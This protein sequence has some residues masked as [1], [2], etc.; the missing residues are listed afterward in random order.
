MYYQ[1][2][3]AIASFISV[4]LVLAAYCMYGFAK[5]QEA[6]AALLNDLNFWSTS[7]LVFIGVSIVVSVVIQIVFHIMLA[8][9]GVVG[10]KLKGKE[11]KDP[12]EEVE[13]SPKEDEMDKLIGLK[14]MRN[15]F[16]VAGAGF[17]MAL[18]S[19]TLQAPSAIM[20]NVLFLS[21][22]VGS[23]IQYISQLYFYRKGV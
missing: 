20:L 23:V 7:M 19:L 15:A 6:G 17:I 11:L 2:K 1:Q 3:K 8:V 9:S 21:F 12:C 14:S 4:V 13:I 22:Y 16:L 5:Y 18:I 10:S